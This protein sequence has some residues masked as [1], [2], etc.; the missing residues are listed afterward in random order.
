MRNK[1]LRSLKSR[2]VSEI[3][4]QSPLR[5]LKKLNIEDHLDEIIANA[6]LYTRPKKGSDKQIIMSEVISI[7]GHNMRKGEKKDSATAARCGA[8]ILYSFDSLG[9]TEIVMTNAANGHGTYIVNVIDE[10]SMQELWETVGR[11]GGKGKLPSLVPYEDWK[12]FKHSTGLSLVKTQS[13]DVAAT[14]TP[15]THPIVFEAVNKSQRVG[16]I[17][18][19]EVYAIAKWALSNKTEA[20]SDIWEQNNPQ[21]RTTK[22]RETKAILSIADKFADTIFYHL[23]Y[24]DF[25]GRKYPTTAY[26]HEQSSD[27]AKGLLLR[28]D[29]KVIGQEG[30]FWLCVSIASNWA[31]SSGREDGA[32][33]DKIPLRDRYHWVLDNEEI[34]TAY[35]MSPKLHQGWMDADKPWQFLAACVELKNALSMGSM[36]LQYESHIEC[37][38]DGSTNGSQ[39]LSALTRDEVTAPYVN[40]VPL[41]M[42]GDLYAYVAAHVWM[43]ID[44][45]LG[46]MQ[47]ALILECEEFIDGLIS[48]KKKI[49]AAEPKSDL[50]AELVMQIRQYKKDWESVGNKAAPVFWGRIKDSKQRRKIVKRNVMTLPYGGSSY[51]LS[52]QQIDDSKKHGIELLM[53]MEHKWAAWMGRLVYEDAKDSLERPMMLLSVF[54][55]AGAAA[56]K[57]GQ[58]LEWVVPVTNFPVV[59]NYTEGKTKRIHIQWGPRIGIRSDTTGYFGNDLQLHVCFIEDQVPSKGKQSQGAAPNVIHSLDAAHLAMTTVRCDFPITTIHDS[60]GCLLADMPKLY[61]I[62]RET[63]VELYQDNPLYPIID[64][65]DG[66]LTYVDMGDLDVNLILESEYAFA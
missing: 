23:Y 16:W 60:Y 29:K 37:F 9:L 3:A 42:P 54:E 55:K 18:N 51:G 28:K 10:K 31:G 20:F 25:R 6:Y 59:Q 35:A 64:K 66:D 63:F 41:D 1:L 56:E 57:R 39:H 15:A 13:R 30:F 32:K 65:I 27:I 12:G 45:V 8:F 52:E 7:L 44:A 14:L 61:R 26:L 2:I 11:Q 43:K 19:Q 4:P 36:Y 47:P 58:F 22:L 38:I 34:L 21:A 17:I 46:R 62:V 50:R 48:L 24:L 5:F 49:V 40:L 53:N 33:T